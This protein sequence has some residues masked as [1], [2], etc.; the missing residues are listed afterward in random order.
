ME[1]ADVWIVNDAVLPIYRGY[2][3]SAPDYRAE[4][5]GFIQRCIDNEAWYDEWVEE[6]R[7]MRGRA[8]GRCV[9]YV[10]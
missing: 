1:D 3:K 5:T 4:G 8:P 7:P 6:R 10:L 9:F 2:C